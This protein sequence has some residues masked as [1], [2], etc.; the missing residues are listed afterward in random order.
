MSSAPEDGKDKAKVAVPV[1]EE[2][3]LD[4]KIAGKPRPEVT[5][6]HNDKRVKQTETVKVSFTVINFR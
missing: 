2:I 1:G 3:R 5:W 6:Y 4:A